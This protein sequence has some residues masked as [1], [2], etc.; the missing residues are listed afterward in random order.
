MMTTMTKECYLPVLLSLEK[1]KEKQKVLKRLNVTGTSRIKGIKINKHE[2]KNQAG[3]IA[4][5]TDIKL[6][7]NQIISNIDMISLIIRKHGV[8]TQNLKDA[9]SALVKE[10]DALKQKL[11]EFEEKG[12]HIKQDDQ[13]YNMKVEKFELTNGETLVKGKQYDMLVAT[14]TDKDAKLTKLTEVIALLRNKLK[15]RE[16]ELS[17]VK[18]DK[19]SLMEVNEEMVQEITSLNH[20]HSTVVGNKDKQITS[21][22]EKY[23]SLVNESTRAL[24]TKKSGSP[25]QELP[26]VEKKK[27][28]DLQRDIEARTLALEDE[29]FSLKEERKMIED[30]K[31]LIDEENLV[32]L[33]EK[34]VIDEEWGDIVRKKK[35]IK[36]TENEIAN[37]VKDLMEESNRISSENA[38]LE[39]ELLKAHDELDKIRSESGPS[40]ADTVNDII[41]VNSRVVESLQ[42]EIKA[43]NGI[44]ENMKSSHGEKERKLREEI[45]MKEGMI[46]DLEY[47]IEQQTVRLEEQSELIEKQQREYVS[48]KSEIKRLTTKIGAVKKRRNSME[49]VSSKRKKP[50]VAHSTVTSEEGHAYQDT[51]IS[52]SPSVIESAVD[53]VALGGVKS[54]VER[55]QPVVDEQVTGNI[56]TVDESSS[57][58][59]RK[60]NETEVHSDEGE[61]VESIA[62]FLDGNVGS[63]TVAKVAPVLVTQVADTTEN[64][65]YD[66]TVNATDTSDPLG[67]TDYTETA[68]NETVTSTVSIDISDV[69]GGDFYIDIDV[70]ELGTATDENVDHVDV[71]NRDFESGQIHHDESAQKLIAAMTEFESLIQS[72]KSKDIASLSEISTSEPDQIKV[73]NGGPEC[74]NGN[75]L[76]KQVDDI[77]DQTKRI[78]SSNKLKSIRDVFDD[79]SDDNEETPCKESE[80]ETV[81]KEEP[82]K[83]S[84]KIKNISTISRTDQDLMNKDVIIPT[85][86]SSDLSEISEIDETVK[87]QAH[88]DSS[89][90]QTQV[91]RLVKLSLDKFYQIEDGIQTQED[92]SNL[93]DNFSKKFTEEITEEYLEKNPSTVGVTV[94]EEHKR[95]LVDQLIFYF[96]TKKSVNM[97]LRK[98]MNPGIPKFSFLSSELS[99]QFSKELID[100]HRVMHNSLAGLSF[101]SDSHQWIGDIIARQL[102]Q[103]MK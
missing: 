79:S 9:N 77:I 103:T 93:T 43:K 47:N 17:R 27:L 29:T 87:T 67:G 14:I 1:L 25:G 6:T 26:A 62:A 16:G 48:N 81:D 72:S 74:K 33:E 60:V 97:N 98:H 91:A 53:E 36:D 7:K 75:N 83:P 30:S 82:I 23:S 39:S 64:V 89:K 69:T 22:Q 76:L 51:L 63:S 44:L 20:R 8:K 4:A 31:K 100:S 88:V 94:T 52:Q 2:D 32:I 21:L 70:G 101:T 24:M 42:A 96:E 19:E 90:L 34:R 15:E 95:Y 71:I 28:E 49:D 54:T 45:S 66:A 84:L 78:D 55:F 12:L 80:N 38:V 18:S 3:S 58:E 11:R 35:E 37:K 46:E 41:Q 61:S 85:E 50:K 10:N 59:F 73:I 40:S 57:A 92:L 102:N 5:K 86:S 65:E 68:G 56:L 13:K 99:N